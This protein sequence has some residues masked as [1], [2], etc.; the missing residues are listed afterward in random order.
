MI[1]KKLFLD[2]KLVDECLDKI[3]FINKN[4]VIKGK[5]SYSSHQIINENDIIKTIVNEFIDMAG[6]EYHLIDIWS[7][8]YD[9]GGYVEEHNHIPVIDILKNVDCKAGVYFYKKP[10]MSGDFILEGKKQNIEEGD[11]ILF[12]SDKN[13][14]SL[15]N[16]T[17]EERIIFSINL[18]KGVKK[19]WNNN[20]WEFIKVYG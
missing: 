15:P 19:I 4:G 16:E 17:N 8:K 9:K 1:K 20:Q 14:Y 6:P 7:Q 10:K 18:A 11:M 5:S 2:N 12:D 13:H 3:S